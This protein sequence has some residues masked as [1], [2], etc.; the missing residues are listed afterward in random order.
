MTA[1][2]LVTI[3]DGIGLE[4]ARVCVWCGGEIDFAPNL[5]FARSVSYNLKASANVLG[6]LPILNFAS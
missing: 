4:T 2:L 5:D 1:A 3:D 6:A